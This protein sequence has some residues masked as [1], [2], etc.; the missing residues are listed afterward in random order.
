MRMRPGSQVI[1]LIGLLLGTAPA[2][3]ETP[4]ERHSA[5][6]NQAAADAEVAYEDAKAWQQQGGGGF[7]QHC[8][9]IA[10][11]GMGEYAQ[12]AQLLEQ[13]GA[14]GDPALAPAGLFSQAAQAWILAG[15]LEHAAAALDTALSL[16]ADDV[17]TMI[18]RAEVAALS[19]DY[20]RA[21]DELNWAEDKAPERAEIYLLRGTAYR[22]LESYELALADLN[23]ALELNPA[24]PE[25][26]LERGNIKRLLAD[27]DGARAD[28]LQVLKLESDG[29]NAEAARANL[30]R[31]DV[32]AN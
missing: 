29:P 14:S 28:W 15:D 30:E 18:D 17:D 2:F 13:L 27:P 31:L 9:A 10:L 4:E 21:V 3:A 6:L 11:V 5:C 7:A 25:S 12:A 26:Y 32:Q 16:D 19:G 22:F 8:A 23:R 1:C 24:S 20:W